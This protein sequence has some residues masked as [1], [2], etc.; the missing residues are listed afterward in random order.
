MGSTSEWDQGNYDGGKRLIS[1]NTVRLAAMKAGAK[2]GIIS[3][4]KCL[5]LSTNLARSPAK[6]GVGV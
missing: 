6:P 5:V 3:I 1:P 2:V 4:S